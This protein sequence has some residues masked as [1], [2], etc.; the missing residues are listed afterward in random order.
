MAIS[1]RVNPNVFVRALAFAGFQEVRD[2]DGWKI[3]LHPNRPGI[4]IAVPVIQPLDPR[5][6]ESYLDAA[7][8]SETEFESCLDQALKSPPD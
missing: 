4:V 1:R 7:G 6:I 2:A 8:I 5:K 3:L